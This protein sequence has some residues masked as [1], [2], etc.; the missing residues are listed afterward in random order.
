MAALLGGNPLKICREGSNMTRA[1]FQVKTTG[2]G[3]KGRPDGERLQ[4]G[5]E[6]IIG[7]IMVT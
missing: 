6:L 1:I 7:S 5:N 4:A 2:G 3:P